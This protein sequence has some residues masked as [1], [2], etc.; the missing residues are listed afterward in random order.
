A[1]AEGAVAAARA[2]GQRERGTKAAAAGAGGDR[3]G[4]AGRTGKHVGGEFLAHATDRPAALG[5]GDLGCEGA[6]V[7]ERALA[8]FVDLTEDRRPLTSRTWALA[9]AEVVVV[10]S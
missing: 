6:L 2:V 3:H 4:H 9:V 1:V 10:H 5:H 8:L 7:D